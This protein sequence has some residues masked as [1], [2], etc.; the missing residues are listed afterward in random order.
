MTIRAKNH[1][2]FLSSEPTR[3][4]VVESPPPEERVP[5]HHGSGVEA[6]PRELGQTGH[7]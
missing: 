2:K 5:P 4:R 7:Y 6:Q 1:Q 3:D